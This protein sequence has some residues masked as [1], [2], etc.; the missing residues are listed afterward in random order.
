LLSRAWRLLHSGCAALATMTMAVVGNMRNGTVSVSV[1]V[2]APRKLERQKSSRQP[3]CGPSPRA[4]APGYSTERQTPR[5]NML[6]ARPKHG[7]ENNSGVQIV[8]KKGD[9]VVWGPA[10]SQNGARLPRIICYGDSNT[11]GFCHDGRKFQPYGQTLVAEL[12][13]A[14]VRCEVAVC[15]LCSFTTQDMLK[16]K[17]SKRVQPPLGPSGRGLLRML[18]EDGVVDLVL[19]MTGTNDMGVQTSLPTTVQHI[20]QLHALCHDRGVPTVAISPTQGSGA[21]CREPRQRLADAIAKWAASATG[22]L[23]C[24]DVEDLV[25]RPVGKDGRSSLPA[26]A[27]HWEHDDL[28]LSAAGSMELGRRLAPHASAWLQRL[29]AD[30]ANLPKAASKSP[31]CTVVVG[32]SRSNGSSVVAPAGRSPLGTL[33]RAAQIPVPMSPLM[34]SRSVS[35]CGFAMAHSPRSVPSFRRSQQTIFGQGA[36]QLCM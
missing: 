7:K 21:G 8:E 22:V 4:V 5:A 28:H 14:G 19:I 32:P 6:G 29:A 10:R 9:V 23:D 12:L 26:S 15:G 1:P 34:T 18:E 27:A 35:G 31:P 24:L 33:P 16:E 2:A 25:P 11:V 13:E 17:A 36:V 30:G 20:A 3:A